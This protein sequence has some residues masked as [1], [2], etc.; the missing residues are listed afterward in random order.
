MLCKTAVARKI[1]M[2]VWKKNIPTGLTQIYKIDALGQFG[3]AVDACFFGLKIEPKAHTV[4]CDVFDTLDAEAPSHVIGFLHGHIIS[5]MTAF[6][7]YRSLL[8]PDKRYIWRSG[9]KHDCSRVMELT[10]TRD[11][12]KNGLDENVSIEDTILF[13]ML[14]GSDIGNGRADCRGAMIVTQQ[15]VGEDTRPCGRNP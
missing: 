15:L 5:D 13:P 10:I 6:N 11:G 14:K 4:T 12:Y 9:V 2:H 8:G 7:N 3:A 1:L